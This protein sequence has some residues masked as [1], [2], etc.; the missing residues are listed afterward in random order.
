MTQP[1]RRA[2]GPTNADL[3]L[4]K[5]LAVLAM[6]IDHYGKI[7]DPSIYAETNAI[8]RLSFPLFA[9]IIGTRLAIRPETARSLLVNL[10]VWGI[11]SQPVYGFLRGSF[12]LPNIFFTLWL[13]V[14]LHV[15]LQNSRGR[16]G[17]VL[18]PL[19]VPAGI[20]A[21]FVDYGMFGPFLIPLVAHLGRRRAELSAV[22]LGPL[23]ILCNVGLVPPMIGPGAA[24][25]L[26]AGPVALLSLR[27][28]MTLPR[29]PKMAFY[30]FY[31]A[32]LL[33]LGL[34]ARL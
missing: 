5:W 33:I 8:G 24:W 26:L 28:G 4:A 12:L 27:S 29:A 19:L 1:T 11:V 3:E 21:L 16:T 25:A 30:A 13:G 32:H 31:P 9:W 15:L 10:L 17:R 34:A 6:A 18:R 23:G 20:A 14:L 2:G 22:L 7:V